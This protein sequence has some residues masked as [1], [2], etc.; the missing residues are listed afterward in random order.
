MIVVVQSCIKFYRQAYAYLFSI[1]K[2]FIE[3]LVTAFSLAN[4][5][6][7]KMLLRSAS[8]FAAGIRLA[9]AAQQGPQTGFSAG[10][11]MKASS[12]RLGGGEVG[13]YNGPGRGDARW[14]YL[15]YSAPGSYS[16]YS[17]R[18]RYFIFV[19]HASDPMITDWYFARALRGWNNDLTFF[20][21]QWLFVSCSWNSKPK[22]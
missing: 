22:M 3:V 20:G 1:R 5:T 11:L 17:Q 19:Q 9:P 2:N 16:T 18:Q 21:L 13:A 6:G 14:Q 7:D 10:A 4:H 15:K 12:P 8:R